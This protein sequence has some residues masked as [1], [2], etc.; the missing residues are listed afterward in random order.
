MG[1]DSCKQ[2]RKSSVP[3]KISEFPVKVSWNYQ[4]IC[5]IHYV[6]WIITSRSRISL[7]QA[8]A[9]DHPTVSL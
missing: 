6:Q 4:R 1:T 9:L 8:T 7:R 5:L 3:A 2:D